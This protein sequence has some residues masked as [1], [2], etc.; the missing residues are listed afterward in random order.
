MPLTTY[1]AGE[2]LTAASL[3]ANLS[4]AASGGMTVISSGSLTGASVAITGIAGYKNLQLQLANFFPATSGQSVII[5]LNNDSTAS[6]YQKLWNRSSNATV[7][8]NS[9]T[10]WILDDGVTN[11]GNTSTTTACV[12]NV[13]NVADT[14]AHKMADLNFYYTSTTPAAII[15]YGNGRYKSTT[16]VTQVNILTTSGNFGGGTYIL[17]GIN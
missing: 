6:Q 15:V 7:L 14:T 8:T 1:T 3:N 11:Q 2:V 12:F 13:Y 16:A 17:Y 10:G 9:D 4:F 5:R